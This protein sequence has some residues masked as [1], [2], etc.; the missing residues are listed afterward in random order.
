MQRPSIGDHILA[1]MLCG[2]QH[3]KTLLV[4]S[5][6]VQLCKA[7][8]YKLVTTLIFIANSIVAANYMNHISTSYTV[9]QK[10]CAFYM[11]ITYHA[12]LQLQVHLLHTLD[13]LTVSQFSTLLLAESESS[14]LSTLTCVYCG[15]CGQRFAVAHL[16]GH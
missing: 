14:I 16:C 10:Y 3:T 5:T 13:G 9:R 4:P 2:T 15:W 11:N 6:H 8:G 12:F 7:L 1:G